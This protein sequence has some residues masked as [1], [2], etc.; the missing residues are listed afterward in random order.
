MLTHPMF[1]P[2]SS[3][4]GFAN[5]PIIVD[6]GSADNKS[7]NFWKKFFTNKKLKVVVMSPKKHDQ[8][9][10]KSQGVTHFIG[11]LIAE[12]GLK[13]SSI[14]SMGTRK[15][16]EIKKQMCDNS[17]QLF[18]NLQTYNPYTKKMHLEI[19]KAYQKLFNMLLPKQINPDYIT[20]GIQGGKGSFNE[21]ALLYYLE[22][23]NIRRYKIKYLYTTENVLH[24]L[25]NGDIDM[26]QF[27]I[28]NHV[29]GIVQESFQAM[30]KYLFTIK[31]EL[32]I[33]I[34]HTLMIKKNISFNVIET[35]MAHPQALAQCKNNLRQKYPNLKQISGEKELANSS[36]IAKCLY[37]Q[38]LPD[39][40][41]MIGS[42]ALAELYDLKIIEENLQDQK[43]NQTTFYHVVRR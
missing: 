27:G 36:M 17:W 9:A 5:L 37:E 18:F 7:F 40:I 33:S 2:Y 11:R 41:A 24:A 19:G 20:Y 14:D 3:Q 28:S 26:G 32:A 21:E 15:L 25:H 1:G 38:K 39:S 31:D 10:A 12:Y 42:K 29:G 43:N 30:G 8:L 23:E 22:R 4:N 13:E 6:R 16:L 34:V 35:I